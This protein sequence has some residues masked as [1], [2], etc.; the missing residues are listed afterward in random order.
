MIDEHWTYRMRDGEV[1]TASRFAK[2]VAATYATPEK[3]ASARLT[4][5][6]LTPDKLERAFLVSRC[7]E[8]AMCHMLGLHFVHDLDWEYEC[9][10]GWDLVFKGCKIDVKASEAQRPKLIWPL[11]KNALL[12]DAPCDWF[13]LCNVSFPFVTLH[14]FVTPQAFIDHH[15]TSDGS[16]RLMPGTWFMHIRQLATPDEWLEGINVSS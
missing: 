3:A 4:M 15:E 14:G 6:N 5:A 11:S 12:Y 7:S 1:Q 13:A 16:D 10:V 9:D 8:I 2:R